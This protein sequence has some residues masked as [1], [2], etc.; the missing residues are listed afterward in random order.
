MFLLDTLDNMPRLRVLDSLM[1]VFLSILREC[2]APDVP[3]FK[4]LRDTQTKLR[5]TTGAT[6]K[7]HKSAHGNL[8]Y[9]NDIRKIIA[10]VSVCVHSIQF[11]V[12]NILVIG[13]R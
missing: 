6:S 13:L 12:P 2:G 9:M 10:N 11:S 7:L 1:K 8:F 4:H 3:S 5:D